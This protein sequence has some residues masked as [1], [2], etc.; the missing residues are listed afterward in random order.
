MNP[1]TQLA[2][3]FFLFFSLFLLILS[4]T[5]WSGVIDTVP[6]LLKLSV[7]NLTDKPVER[8]VPYVIR[9]HPVD[10]NE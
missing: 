8:C 4:G 1:A 5:S 7:N 6:P 10:N 3:S 9:S 2:F